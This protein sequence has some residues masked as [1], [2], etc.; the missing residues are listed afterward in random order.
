MKT[1]LCFV[2]FSLFFATNAQAYVDPGVGYFLWQT[3]LAGLV[4]SLFFVVKLWRH[5]RQFATGRARGVEER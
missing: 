2:I 3:V 5:L 4:G 1:I